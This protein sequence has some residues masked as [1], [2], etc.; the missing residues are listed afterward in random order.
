MRKVLCYLLFLPFLLLAS[1]DVYEWP[2]T[3]DFAKVHLRLHYETD[4]TKW[5]L[6]Y[7]DMAIVDQGTGETYNN[8][9]HSG[10][11]RYV[12]RAYPISQKQ[13]TAENHIME[14]VFTKDIAEGYNHEVTLDMPTGSYNIMVWSDLVESPGDKYF[15]NADNFDEIKLQ[16]DHKGSTDHRDAFRGTNTITLETDYAE[17]Q[18]DTLDVTMQRPLAKFEFIT[19]DLQ[20]FIEKEMEAAN[21]ESDSKEDAPATK[22]DIENYLA[23]YKVVFYYSGFMPD[24]YNM[25]IDKP[26]DSAMG[27]SFESGIKVLNNDEA[28]LG[29][30]YVFVNGKESGIT[31][32]IGLYNKDNKQ[33][34]LSEPITIPLRRNRHS[35]LKGS[36]MMQKSSGGININPNFNGNHNLIIE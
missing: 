36:F 19:T 4:I 33:I 29:F 15:Y 35:I 8:E 25:N 20:Q 17:Q 24:T 1:C 31:V 16:G 27:V 21:Q 11:I 7:K 23:D 5:N 18:P 34:A 9:Q 12:I 14:Y 26:I 6:A 3:S 10:K 13:R 2:D 28:S 32:Q 22:V 30:D